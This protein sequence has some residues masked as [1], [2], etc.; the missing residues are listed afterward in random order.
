MPN[1]PPLGVWGRVDNGIGTPTEMVD[2]VATLVGETTPRNVL[3]V[4]CG[5]S[6]GVPRLVW[7]RSVDGPSSVSA[8]Y[9]GATPAK[10]GKVTVSW[11]PSSPLRSDSYQVLRADGSLVGVASQF[12]TSMVDTGPRPV[13]GGYRVAGV[14]AG[15][16]DATPTVSASLNLTTGPPTLS[17]LDGGELLRLSWTVPTWGKPHGYQV[18][19]DGGLYVSVDGSTTTYD[20]YGFVPGQTHTYQV[21]AVLSGVRGGGSPTHTVSFIPPVPVNVSLS[22]PAAN[23]LRLNFA[24]PGGA[25]TRYE[26]QRYDATVGFVWIDH[27]LNNGSGQSDWATTTGYGYMRVRSVGANGLMS[28]YTQV[29]PVSPIVPPPVAIWIGTIGSGYQVSI[30][31]NDASDELV[32]TICAQAYW[33]GF[34]SY[35]WMNTNPA[36]QAGTNSGVMEFHFDRLQFTPTYMR[37]RRI[38]NGVS[39]AWAQYGPV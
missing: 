12:Q 26:V 23:L 1:V 17:S 13:A 22:S 4:W 31:L 24:Y 34:P 2:G 14:L 10:E 35:D 6:A 8:V 33:S 20:D 25:I 27:D 36:C 7:V 37:I 11:V 18:Y 9:T 16:V 19:R 29:G 39:S 15:V 30:Q 3:E 28:G 38:R 5:D 32:Q 21:F